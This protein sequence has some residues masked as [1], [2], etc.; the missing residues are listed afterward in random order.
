[1]ITSINNTFNTII[2]TI[3][4]KKKFIRVQNK[5]LRIILQPGIFQLILGLIIVCLFLFIS[6]YANDYEE[7]ITQK[8]GSPLRLKY[9]NEPPGITFFQ[10]FLRS[11]KTNTT[12]PGM[13]NSIFQ[14]TIKETNEK[15]K[16]H[17]FHLLGTDTQGN[18]ILVNI[19]KGAKTAL[20]GSIIAICV[21]LLF[22][23]PAGI[24]T[25]YFGGKFKK[26]SEYISALIGTLPKLIFLIIIIATLGYNFI[27][28]MAT[29]GF[30]AST[31][32]KDII[33]NKIFILKKNQFIEAARELGV[34]KL[35]IIFKHILWHNCKL[36]LIIQITYDVAE[37]IL[38]EASLSYIG[39]GIEDQISWGG[40]LSEG[41]AYIYNQ[42]YWM[43][44][45]PAVA[46]IISILAFMF[47]AD[48]LQKWL[49]YREGQVY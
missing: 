16:Y 20:L 41:M 36:A 46:I 21:A 27:V 33:E 13:E 44:F 11:D 40:M 3:Q 19:M 29:I 31:K 23:V 34:S 9:V 42:Q 45:F 17:K 6:Y 10:K 38:L 47:I 22:G 49:S 1:M 25:G 32:I 14:L 26:L 5:F 8:R 30:F 43:I 48:G 2:S 18:D 7:L 24:L 39:Y 12:N 4:I 28:I 15:E 37:V 35:K